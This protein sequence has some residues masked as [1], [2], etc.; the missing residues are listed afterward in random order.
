MPKCWQR[1]DTSASE[2]S[3]SECA[4]TRAP[5]AVQPSDRATCCLRSESL[6][7]SGSTSIQSRAASVNR[8][9]M[10]TR[11]KAEDIHREGEP[12]GKLNLRG[13]AQAM[14]GIIALA[15]V[16]MKSDMR[17]LWEVIK[18]ARI[19]YLPLAVVC[20]FAVT[21]LMAYRWGAILKVRGYSIKP[22]RLFGYYLIGIF[23][24]NFVPGGGISGDVARL[25]YVDREVR[26]K[27]FVLSTLVYE[28]LVGGMIILLIGLIS[29]LASR[30]YI[31]ADQIIR[32]SELMLGL[33]II[34]ATMLM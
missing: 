19:A 4:I 7:A 3:K 20:S 5:L 21:W 23:F 17:G 31:Q 33:V 28:R 26:D 30:Q 13:V 18:S 34:S 24:M 27:A 25:I 15:L 29:T 14:I 12:R 6:R 32:A 11:D 8:N 1:Q 2:R 10:T 16:I 9:R 22:H